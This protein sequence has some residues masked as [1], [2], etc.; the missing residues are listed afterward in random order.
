MTARKRLIHLLVLTAV[1]FAVVPWSVLAAPPSPGGASPPGAPTVGAPPIPGA[2]TT[3]RASSGLRLREGPSLSDPIIRILYN[4]ETVYPSAG[5]V[6]NEGISWT[7]VTVYR[8]G[9]TY[10]GFCAS[11]YLA[12]SGGYV[13]PSEHGLKVVASALRLRSGPGLSYSIRR[14]VPYGTVLQP[15]G[16][17]QWGSGLQWSQVSVDGVYV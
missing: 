3:V 11:R 16:A 10:Q 7:F 5:P 4:G 2:P 12:T 17:T 6:W 14:V 9:Y 15:T 1:V 8:W 13:P